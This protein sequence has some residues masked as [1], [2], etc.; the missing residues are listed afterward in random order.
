M[1]KCPS[2]RKKAILVLISNFEGQILKIFKNAYRHWKVHKKSYINDPRHFSF[3][4]LFPL[5]ISSPYE[6]MLFPV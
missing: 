1:K 3:K 5:C 2:L 6:K 4:S